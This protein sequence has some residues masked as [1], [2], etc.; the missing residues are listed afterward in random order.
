MVALNPRLESEF[1]RLRLAPWTPADRIWKAVLLTCAVFGALNLLVGN[2]IWGTAFLLSAAALS[3]RIR[4]YVGRCVRRQRQVP[5]G[6][7]GGR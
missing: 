3:P 1:A 5:D 7:T 6:R 4:F 2:Q